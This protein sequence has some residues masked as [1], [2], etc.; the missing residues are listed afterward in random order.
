M[1]TVLLRLSGFTLLPLLGLVMPLLL[2]P[3][4]A[5]VVGAQGWASTLAGQAIGTFA[6]TI[7]LWG[8]NVEGPILIAKTTG[9]PERAEIYARSVRTRLLTLAVVAPLG[10]LIAGSN[11]QPGF[12]QT[13]MAMALAITLQG[14]SPAFYGIGAGS[15]PLLAIYDTFPRFVAV[16]VSVPL[17]LI[18]NSVWVYPA[19]Q[20]L[21]MGIALVI[22]HRRHAAGTAWF[23]S[24]LRDTVGQIWRQRK[25][26]GFQLAGNA[27]AA[28][29]IPIANATVPLTAGPLATTD[30]LYRYGLFAAVALGNALQGWTLE[31]G[32]T[33]RRRRLAAAIW[34]HLGL[35][36][37]GLV[38]LTLAGPPVS[39][40][41]SAGKVPASTELCLLY[42]VAFLAISSSTPFIRNLLIP[43]GRDGLVLGATIISAVF[44][45]ATMIIA[46]LL[47]SVPGVAAGMALSEIVLVMLLL[48][49]GLRL[50]RT[51]N[52]QPPQEQ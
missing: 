20:G 32:V 27:Y 36:V 26:A 19:V 31:P 50:L 35:G 2:L 5:Q 48:G 49:P 6:S 11:A 22:F 21:T 25:V 29:P 13:S 38:V 39:R 44:G 4:L 23:P 17:L 33:D 47:D 1:R 30:Q 24:D 8:W 41:I 42:G 10:L 52:D 40:I 9:Q 7:V 16:L 34:A 28:T 51:A 14:L 46:G 43:A 45:V 3:V 18:T 15:P 12:A 37:V